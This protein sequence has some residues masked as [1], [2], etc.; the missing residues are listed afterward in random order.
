MQRLKINIQGVVQGVGFR[1]FVYRLAN[2]LDLKGRV[3]NSPQG[4]Q[5]DLEGDNENLEKFLNRL[6]SD[7]PPLASINSTEIDRLEEII[8]YKDFT[9]RTSDNNG[10]KSALVL[11]DTATCHDCLSEIFDP[12]DR[13]HRYPFTNCTNCGPR[14]SIIHTLPYDRANTTM[15]IFPMCKKCRDE[16]EDPANRRFH[17]QPNACPEC[18]PHLELW[19][20][21]GKVLAMHDDALLAACETIRQGKIVA[22]KGLGG[23]QLLVDARDDH[24][25]RRLRKR[26]NREEKPFALMYPSLDNAAIDCDIT[27]VEKNLLLSPQSPIVLLQKLNNNTNLADNVAPDNPYLGVMLP[28]TPLHYLLMHE[29]QFPVIATSGNLSDEPICIDEHEALHRLK[30]IADLYL[31]HNRPIARQVDDSVVR[32]MNGSAMVVRN[33]RGYAPTP[34]ELMGSVA[35]TLA[36]GAHLKNSVAIARGNF[37]FAGQ[38]IGDLET[39]EAFEAMKKTTVSLSKIYDFKQEAVVCDL[40]P[41]YLSTRFAEN[42]GLP[43][44]KVQHHL[45][46]VL[47]CMA[48]NK[49]SEPVLGVSWDGTGLGPDKTVWGGEFIAVDGRAAE[50]VAHLRLFPL[51][52]GDKAVKEPRRTALGL[53]YEI[54]GSDIFGMDELAPLRAF[55]KPEIAILQK[56]LENKINTPLTSSTGRLF[57]AVSS[58]LG[59]CHISRY[60]GQ[61]AM[62]LEYAGNSKATEQRYHYE[63]HNDKSKFIIDWEPMIREILRDCRGKISPGRIASRFQNTLA[64][65]ILSVCNSIGQENI[66]LTGGCFQNKYLTEKTISRLESAGFKPYRHHRI[67]P[68]DGGIALGQIIAAA[69]EMEIEI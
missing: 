13:R 5:I 61:A 12:T 57:D 65:I 10:D 4:V 26:K 28:Y 17:A 45:A 1:P 33:A 52:G 23:F 8:G 46:H 62:M 25:V 16:Y 30:N 3:G 41:D 43:I 49:I 42:S 55:E 51:P 58:I 18:G 53:L 40:H 29:L 31:V 14:Y 9:V 24:A 7:K 50:R 20:K 66:V 6:E 15:Q 32:V 54:Y 67:P 27:S 2:E 11:P 59:I 48:D 21:S 63:I 19:D 69:G 37:A 60:E 22:L 39:T 68:N 38:H 44:R 36:V 64:D 35:S 34:V 56:A 47:S